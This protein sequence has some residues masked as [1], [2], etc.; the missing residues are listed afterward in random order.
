[1]TYAATRNAIS[2]PGSAAGRMRSVSRCGL[3]ID[4]FGRDLAPASPS[5]PPASGKARRTS[6]TS[7][8]SSDASSKPADRPSSSASK[9]RAPQSLAE[10]DRAYQQRY[11]RRNRARDLMRHARMR[12]HKKGLP[13][14]LD[15][16]LPDLQRRI[17][18]GLC[19]ISG[20]PF[21]LDGGR[22]WDSPSFDRIDPE[23]GYIYE[24][25]RVVLHAA[26]SAMGDWG[27]AKMLE[28]AR[29]ILARRQ[30]ASNALSEKLGQNLM[31]SLGVNGSPEYALTWNRSVTQSGHVMYRLR[32]SGHRI[33]G[34]GFGG[35][36][37]A[38]QTDG[39]KNV[40]SLEGSLREVDR[41]GGPQDLCQAAH[42]AGWPTP[43]KGNADGSQMA[44]DASA[45]G[46]RPDGSKATV[47]LNQVATLAGWPTPMAGSPA[48]DTY[49]EAGNT[50]SSRK[51]VALAGWATPAARD[52]RSNE[53]SEEHH[54]ARAAHS[55]GKPLSE[56]AHQVA[57]GVM[58]PACR[59]ATEKPGALNPRFSLWL[60][61]YPTE[62]A[63]CGERVTRSFRKSR[64]R[65]SAQQ[66]KP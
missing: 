44:K 33:S 7:G 38:R 21:N 28:I 66:T 51:T 2:S 3:T 63:S 46:K 31:A 55:R 17:D 30:A 9:S 5:A 11:R 16:F 43:T 34:S 64:R 14:N 22:T 50:D 40:R 52:W 12:A 32:A 1:M 41:K 45:T 60:M 59:A 24:N 54:A 47:S 49:N 13:F 62:W 39:E 25:I 18:V 4:L 65:S 57:G 48:T 35:W 27:D 29:A 56:Q 37:T 61:G 8:P 15:R 20:L 19:E 26:N 53:A 23:K 42:L 58:P 36:P 6:A 10:R